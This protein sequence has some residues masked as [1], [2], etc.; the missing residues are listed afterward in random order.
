ME[1]FWPLEDQ[2]DNEGFSVLK[3]TSD[4]LDRSN[5]LL[6]NSE[7]DELSGDDLDK[8]HKVLRSELLHHKYFYLNEEVNREMY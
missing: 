5:P 8:K 1:R 6:Q 3:K 7:E 4:L 2:K